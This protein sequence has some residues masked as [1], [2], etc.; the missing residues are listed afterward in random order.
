MT[1]Q[2]PPWFKLLAF[3]W[4]VRLQGPEGT[5]G[6]VSVVVTY[7]CMGPICR[8]GTGPSTVI[9]LTEQFNFECTSN[10]ASQDLTARESMLAA[11]GTAPRDKNPL[12]NL[13]T[14]LADQC[15]Q[16][17]DPSV[18]QAA[19]VVTHCRCKFT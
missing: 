15:S 13:N 18:A 12:A 9:T 5:V 10:D 19:N 8:A 2:T 3:S 7:M 1:A 4:S 11:A 17:V 16:C 6:G 14:P